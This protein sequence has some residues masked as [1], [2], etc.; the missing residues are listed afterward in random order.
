MCLT[1]CEYLKHSHNQRRNNIFFRKYEKK[2]NDVGI[3]NKY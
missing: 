3:G 1:Y 2:N